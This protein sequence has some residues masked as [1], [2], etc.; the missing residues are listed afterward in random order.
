LVRRGMVSR[1]TNRARRDCPAIMVGASSAGTNF[2]PSQAEPPENHDHDGRRLR[3]GRGRSHP[4]AVL[5]TIGALI[6]FKVT[7]L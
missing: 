5:L 6:H 3:R 4:F 7:T 1:Y 2:E